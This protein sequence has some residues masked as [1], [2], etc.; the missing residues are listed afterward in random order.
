MDDF[1]KEISEQLRDRYPKVEFNIEKNYEMTIIPKDENGFEIFVQQGNRENTIHFGSW[2]FHFNNDKDGKNEL[3]DY[4]G[5]GM[6]KL[7]RLKAYL[8]NGKEYKWT[9]ETKNEENGNWYPAGTMR[10]MNFQFWKKPTV[11]YYQND[12]IKLNDQKE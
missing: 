1:I 5:L 10:L 6:S 12:L 8:R 9:F 4:L 3:L 7:G 11:K 2:H